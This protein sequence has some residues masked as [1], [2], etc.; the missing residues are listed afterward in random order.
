MGGFVNNHYWSSTEFNN[1]I[2]W[3][4]SFNYGY[5]D[6]YKKYEALGVRAIRAF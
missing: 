2:A 5:Q 4:Q 3:I 1:S 6:A